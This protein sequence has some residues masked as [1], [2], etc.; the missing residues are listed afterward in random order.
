MPRSEGVEGSG[1]EGDYVLYVL[2]ELKIPVGR[3]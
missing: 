3:K 1:V 2:S